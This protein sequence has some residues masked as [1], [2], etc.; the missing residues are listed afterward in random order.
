[1]K[2]EPMHTKRP[3]TSLGKAA[4]RALTRSA[5]AARVTAARFNTK[6][7]VIE[8]GRVVSLVPTAKT[9]PAPKNGQ[10]Q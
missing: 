10:P 9:V 2:T 3:R 5:S 8:G 1:M 6:I 7:H 4:A